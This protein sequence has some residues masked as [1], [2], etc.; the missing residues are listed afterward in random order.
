MREEGGGARGQGCVRVRVR[1]NG[2]TSV[3]LLRHLQRIGGKTAGR[4]ATRAFHST[5]RAS[6]RAEGECLREW[7]V[8]AEDAVLSK[9]ERRGEATLLLLPRLPALSKSP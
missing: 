3:R 4:N 7:G 8:T 1:A 5:C 9:G 2:V 6:V